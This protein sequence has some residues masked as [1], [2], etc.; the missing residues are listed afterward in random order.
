MH[1]VILE[2]VHAIIILIYLELRI[3]SERS[4]FNMGYVT[5]YYAKIVSACDLVFDI[6]VH[7]EMCASVSIIE[8]FICK[9]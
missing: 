1:L 5:H 3:T 4:H 9:E 2:P 7:E 8:V 6:H